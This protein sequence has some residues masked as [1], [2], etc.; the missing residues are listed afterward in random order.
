MQDERGQ[1]HLSDGEGYYL[2]AVFIMIKVAMITGCGIIMRALI[3]MLIT[4]EL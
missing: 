1:R 4:G 3:R 2:M